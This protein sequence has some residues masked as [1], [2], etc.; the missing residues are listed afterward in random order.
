MTG[1]LSYEPLQDRRPP[2]SIAL[3][4][5][6]FF[7]SLAPAP[8]GWAVLGLESVSGGVEV[9]GVLWLLAGGA[10]TAVT[11][12]IGL[13]GWIGSYSRS[14]EIQKA[15]RYFAAAM[16]MAGV[17]IVSALACLFIGADL[18]SRHPF[19]LT[20]ANRTNVA[21]KVIVHFSDRDV[22]LGPL[23]PGAIVNSSNIRTHHAGPIN[24][25]VTANGHSATTQ[26]ASY[27]DEDDLW[28]EYQI[29]VTSDML[30]GGPPTT[31]P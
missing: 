3:A 17:S 2:V 25:T 26:A 12:L 14:G 23:S 30:P 27:A 31:S 7:I 15:R 1:T 8:I 29:D 4:K 22:P 19:H 10:I 24:M 6:N 20:I 18:A 11:A 16:A 9:L 28:G 13:V 5:G 21:V